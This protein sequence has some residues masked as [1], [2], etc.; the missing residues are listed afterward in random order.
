LPGD[1]GHALWRRDFKGASGLFAV[2]LRPVPR[3]ALEAFFDSLELFGI[4]LSWGGY[5]SLCLPMDAPTR[6]VRPWAHR[7]PLLRIH[8]GLESCQ[9]LVRDMQSA[10]R[11][12]QRLA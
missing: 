3:P 9:D 10:L 12:M 1:P 8:A 4:G 7:G 11:R 5:E 2:A 6:S